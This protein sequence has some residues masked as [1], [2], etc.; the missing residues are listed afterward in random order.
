MAS[1]TQLDVRGTSNCHERPAISVVLKTADVPVSS[2]G[3]NISSGKSEGGCDNSDDSNR[4]SYGSVETA[5]EAMAAAPVVNYPRRVVGFPEPHVYPAAF[6]KQTNNLVQ[7]ATTQDERES[8]KG[9]LKRSLEAASTKITRQCPTRVIRLKPLETG[10]TGFKALGNRNLPENCL[11][12]PMSYSLPA[13]SSSAQPA[14]LFKRTS[15]VAIPHQP[16]RCGSG[17]TDTFSLPLPNYL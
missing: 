17:T 14:E 7:Q 3:A 15:P 8:F 12:A 16:K 6:G 9:E 11:D 13:E 10:S 4:S 5:L 1:N 2:F